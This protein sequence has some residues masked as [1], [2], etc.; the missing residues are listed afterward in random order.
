MRIGRYSLP[1]SAPLGKHR[2]PRVGGAPQQAGALE[3]LVALRAGR[4]QTRTLQRI[5]GKDF[6]ID[7]VWRRLR[8]FHRRF[9]TLPR[10]AK[11][12]QRCRP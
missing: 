6:L 8:F 7:P 11:G 1:R 2:T 4:Q 9:I 3:R 12:Q 5:R 10:H